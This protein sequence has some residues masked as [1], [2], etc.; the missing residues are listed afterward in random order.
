MKQGGDWT[1]ATH[2][3]T[4]LQVR[5]A[6]IQER[7]ALHVPNASKATR[8]SASGQMHTLTSASL[9]QS[10]YLCTAKRTHTRQT[11]LNCQQIY[12]WV[13][14]VSLL[15]Y[16]SYALALQSSCCK[17]SAQKCMPCLPFSGVQQQQV[18][19]SSQYLKSAV[20][21]HTGEVSH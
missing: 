1:S 5:L 7:W 16:V 21:C 19:R 20:K 3:L 14:L 11:L 13:V 9:M 18:L 17:H 6:I 15:V 10:L 4:Y 8:Q 2:Y 12:L